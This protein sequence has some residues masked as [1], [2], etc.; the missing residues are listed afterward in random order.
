MLKNRC[1]FNELEFRRMA[2]QFDAIF[3]KIPQQP[4]QILLT[5]LSCIKPQPK[6]ED[7]IFWKCDSSD[8]SDE[9]RHQ[10]YSTLEIPTFVSNC[11]RR[12]R[13]AFAAKFTKSN[14]SVF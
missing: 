8:S 14:C 3:K 7:Q 10:F 1:T 9:A 6:N 2:E 11:S 12:F 13:P 5:T 4:Q